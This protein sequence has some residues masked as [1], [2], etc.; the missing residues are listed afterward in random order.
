MKEK[1]VAKRAKGDKTPPSF[2]LCTETMSL[3]KFSRSFY[4]VFYYAKYLNCS[5]AKSML[6]GLS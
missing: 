6:L 1:G 4:E 2:F 3:N 5:V